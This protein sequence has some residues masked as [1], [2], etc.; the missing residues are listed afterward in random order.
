[1]E[2]NPYVD[3]RKMNIFHLESEL[4]CWVCKKEIGLWILLVRWLE[5]KVI[6]RGRNFPKSVNRFNWYLFVSPPEK[7]IPNPFGAPLEHL[8]MNLGVLWVR[9]TKEVIG[10]ELSPSPRFSSS[11]VSYLLN[12]IYL[13]WNN[14]IVLGPPLSQSST[15]LSARLLSIK[16]K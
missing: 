8:M 7:P 11:R 4:F 9:Q 16:L 3:Y 1:M 12:P 14:S 2:T 15:P 6:F 5:W 10:I 13:T